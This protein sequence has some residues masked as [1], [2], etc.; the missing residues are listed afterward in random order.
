MLNFK[1]KILNKQSLLK[2]PFKTFIRGTERQPSSGVIKRPLNIAEGKIKKF[3]K[4]AQ[5]AE[6]A[7]QLKALLKNQI[8]LGGAIPLDEYINTCLYH[9]DLGY[10]TSKEHVFGEKGDYITAPELSHVFGE[11]ITLFIYKILESLHFPKQYD[12]L[13]IG[14]G[15][16]FLMADVINA[17]YDLKVLKGINFILIEKSPKLIK[18]Q[19]EQIYNKFLKLKIFPEFVNQKDKGTEGFVDKKH[20]ITV[21]WYK[22]MEQLIT[23]RTG[24]ILHK[25]K[26]QNLFKHFPKYVQAKVNPRLK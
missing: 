15:R 4:L 5:S 24:T 19:Q 7:F 9:P 16:G 3:Q 12:L 22:D 13:E 25:S 8:D 17:L 10:Y 26:D 21:T 23:H 1:T 11:M 14:P 18:I 2:F 6:S 20:K